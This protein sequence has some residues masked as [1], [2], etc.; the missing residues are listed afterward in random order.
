[1][2]IVNMIVERNSCAKRDDLLET[3]G[4]TYM[5]IMKSGLNNHMHVQKHDPTNG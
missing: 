5:K 4:S 1:M 3:L 2:A